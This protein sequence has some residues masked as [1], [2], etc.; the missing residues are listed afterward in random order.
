MYKYSEHIM[1]MSDVQFIDFC[2]QIDTCVCNV[3]VPK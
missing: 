2:V 1:H 3:Y